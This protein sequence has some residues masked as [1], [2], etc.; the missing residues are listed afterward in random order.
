M[1]SKVGCGEPVL[2]CSDILQDATIVEER[3]KIN[4]LVKPKSRRLTQPFVLL[5]FPGGPEMLVSA[6]SGRYDAMRGIAGVLFDQVKPI[7]RKPMSGISPPDE[8]ERFDLFLQNH[9]LLSLF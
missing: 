8:E 9:F 3:K 5:L 7:S 2:V 4:V 1:W 6:Q